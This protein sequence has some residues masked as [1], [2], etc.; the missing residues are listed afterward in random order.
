M[1]QATRRTAGPGRSTGVAE[2]LE[3]RTVLTRRS[4]ARP[5]RGLVAALAF[6]FLLVPAPARAA[7]TAE[8]VR[9]A[10]AAVDAVAER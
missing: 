6:A 9:A 3:V 7:T 2:H 8:Q 1:R 4:L 10:R 5:S